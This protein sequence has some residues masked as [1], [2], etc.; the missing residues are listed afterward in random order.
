LSGEEVHGFGQIEE[1]L[2]PVLRFVRRQAVESDA[3]PASRD[4]EPGVDPV[5]RKGNDEDL[6]CAPHQFSENPVKMVKMFQHV[7]ADDRVEGIIG[8]RQALCAFEVHKEIGTACDIDADVVAIGQQMPQMSLVATDIEN[9]SL[10]A[11]GKSRRDVFAAIVSFVKRQGFDVHGHSR[12]CGRER[13]RG[14]FSG[15]DRTLHD[16]TLRGIGTPRNR[17]G[18][19]RPPMDHQ[20]GFAFKMIL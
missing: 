16:I 10:E 20:Y 19:K 3:S 14:K 7:A 9:P 17:P 12:E 5:V 2:V 4:G 18:R 13:G 8:E 6:S 15:A 1:P 11:A